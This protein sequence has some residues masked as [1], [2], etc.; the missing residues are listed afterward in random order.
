MTRVLVARVL[1]TRARAEAERTAGEL[2]RRGFTPLIAPVLDIAATGA[3]IPLDDFDAALATS[4]RA[5]LHA[6]AGLEALRAPF[7]VVGAN[8][9]EALAA[10]GRRVEARAAD[11]A[12]LIASLRA[13]FRAPARFLYLAGRDRKTELEA[14]LA[15]AGHEATIVETYA[16]RAAPALGAEA[17]AALAK[18]EVGAVL[19]YSARSAAIFLSLA[20]QAK[21]PASLRESVSHLALSEEIARALK[22]AGCVHV[23]AAPAPEE[24]ALL[25]LLEDAPNGGG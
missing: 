2:R 10:R 3:A 21:A 6:G 8:T 7:H 16:A 19:H 11:V 4:A 18:G 12:G 1:V 9:A 22:Q 14:F 20:D 23:R 5:A 13:R 17:V 24:D 15:A 25:A